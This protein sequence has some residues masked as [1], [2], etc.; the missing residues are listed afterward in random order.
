MFYV[1]GFLTWP[2]I[3]CMAPFLHAVKW[4]FKGC[5]WYFRN[6]EIKDGHSK[7]RWVDILIVH[8]FKRFREYFI[9]HINGV[10]RSG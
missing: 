3:A 9:G 4:A 7:W 10:Q 8:F 5:L 6:A 1:A 2:L